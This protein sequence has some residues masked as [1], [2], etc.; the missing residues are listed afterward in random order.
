MRVPRPWTEKDWC[1]S[2]EEP[3]WPLAY[4]KYAA[5]AVETKGRVNSNLQDMRRACATYGGESKCHICEDVEDGTI[6]YQLQ[7]VAWEDMAHNIPTVTDAPWAVGGRHRFDFGNRDKDDPDKPNTNH[8][9]VCVMVSGRDCQRPLPNPA[10]FPPPSF[11]RPTEVQAATAGFQHGSEVRGEESTGGRDYSN[12][13]VRCWGHIPSP[14]WSDKSYYKMTPMHHLEANFYDDPLKDHEDL[15][16][17]HDGAA[18]TSVATD[19]WEY[20]KYDATLDDTGDKAIGASA[21]LPLNEPSHARHRDDDG[22]NAYD[23]NG[24]HNGGAGN[25]GNKNEPGDRYYDTNHQ[26]PAAARYGHPLSPYGNRA[27]SGNATLRRLRFNPQGF[28]HTVA[29]S[30]KYGYRDGAAN[31]AEFREP[32][33]NRGRR[34]E[35]RR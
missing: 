18:D 27:A 32:Q 9:H 20:P 6:A 14:G 11:S 31:V 1:E 35:L 4:Q 15:H 33:V 8:V 12:C 2:V 16:R 17:T 24:F 10:L 25:S 26:N 5:Q 23:G 3:E 29:G 34:G 7:G 30:G 28:A 22:G 19:V 21:V 13:T